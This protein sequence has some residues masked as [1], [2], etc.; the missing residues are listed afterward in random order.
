MLPE[1]HIFLVDSLILTEKVMLE[2]NASFMLRV[3][4]IC[5]FA[6]MQQMEDLL[7]HGVKTGWWT[8]IMTGRQTELFRTRIYTYRLLLLV[9][10][11]RIFIF[12][13]HEIT[14]D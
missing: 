14:R 8:F 4:A 5:Y 10:F 3:A 11:I 2:I 1:R 7:H 13:D 6:L 9:S 12:V